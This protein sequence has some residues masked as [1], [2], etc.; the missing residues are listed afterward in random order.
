MLPNGTQND[1]L[2]GPKSSPAAPARTPQAPG[3]PWELPWTPRDLIL[4]A[5]EV[6]RTPFCYHFGRLHA[7]ARQ[8]F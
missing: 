3:P 8:S 1:D 2:G 5:S 6:P 4:A 7:F